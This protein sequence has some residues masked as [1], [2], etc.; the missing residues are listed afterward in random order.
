MKAVPKPRVICSSICLTF[1]KERSKVESFPDSEA[2]RGGSLQ[3][4]VFLE[5][6]KNSQ[7]NTCVRVFFW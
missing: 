5:I 4:Q 6:S 7:E 1:V 3:E 2:A